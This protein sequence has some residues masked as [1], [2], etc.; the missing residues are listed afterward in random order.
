MQQ[1]QE[2]LYQQQ[3]AQVQAQQQ[4]A[5]MVGMLALPTTANMMNLGN[6]DYELPPRSEEMS[7]LF[8]TGTVTDTVTDT[9]T[10]RF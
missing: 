7:N 8:N 9:D 5:A 3:M 1:Q 4:Q 10:V 2:V 6:D